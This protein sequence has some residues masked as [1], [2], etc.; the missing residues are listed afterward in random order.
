MKYD[1]LKDYL[2][3]YLKA[4]IPLII[5]DTVEKNRAL[6]LIK[7]VQNNINYEF[8]LFKLSEGIIN[9]RDNAQI[10]DENTIAG[11][12]DY[13][14]ADIKTKDNNNYMRSSRKM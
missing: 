5:I 2:T 12:L 7:E 3:R 11:A 8:K 10:T 1:E 14:A 6:R 4:R 9:L 13:I